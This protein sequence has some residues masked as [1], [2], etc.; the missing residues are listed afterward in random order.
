MECASS[1]S[2]AEEED[3]IKKLNKQQEKIMETKEVGE[4][5]ME[6]LTGVSTSKSSQQFQEQQQGILANKTF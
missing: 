4:Q 2:P 5:K 6:E 1:L 3:E